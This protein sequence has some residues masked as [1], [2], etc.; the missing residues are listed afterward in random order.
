MPGTAA[1]RDLLDPFDPEQAIPAAARLLVDLR[2]QF[3]NIGLAAAAYNAG[4][5]RVSAWLDGSG[6]LPRETLAYVFL[7]TGRTA[8]DWAAA[9]RDSADPGKPDDAGSCLQVTGAL[10]TEEGAVEIAVAPWGVQLSGDFSKQVALASFERA[11]QRYAGILGSFQPMVVGTRLLSRGTRP[12]YRV[13][14]PAMSRAQANQICNA[15]LLG[16]GAC[17][18]VRT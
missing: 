12:F 17:V 8:D 14:V 9:G 13:M 6:G 16:G 11:R 5:A 15:I 3:G 10:R 4:A 2:R 7:L 18:A 1:Q